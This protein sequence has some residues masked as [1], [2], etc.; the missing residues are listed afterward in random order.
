MSIL[1]QDLLKSEGKLVLFFGIDKFSD[2]V[3][4]S[5][6]VG[7]QVVVIST[8][9]GYKLF[10]HGRFVVNI[11]AHRVGNNFIIC[12]MNNKQRALYVFYFG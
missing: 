9:D 11:L 10:F 6:R 7:G 4:V 2:W 5:G 1:L 8:L 12:A 3:P